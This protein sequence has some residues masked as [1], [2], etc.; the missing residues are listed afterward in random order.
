MPVRPAAL[1]ALALM[2]ITACG[3]RD[4]PPLDAACT[5]SPGAIERAL[6]RAP[7][8]VTL[9][10]GVRLSDCVS[11]ARS[12]AELQNAGAVLTGAADHLAVRATRGDAGAGL[13]LGYL[14]GAA[15][16]G[17]A[18]TP[19]L[20]AQLA[21]RMESAAAFVDEGGPAVAAA[22]ERGMRAGRATG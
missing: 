1:V 10:G 5:A 7:E 8:P 20:Q 15:R 11:R 6:A 12:D 16:R 21:R 22:L 13:A 14:V 9:G 4:H 19:G 17:A 3:G 2:A 18:R